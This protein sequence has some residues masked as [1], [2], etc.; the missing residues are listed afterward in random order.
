MAI[1]TPINLRQASIYSIFIRNFTPEGTFRAVIPELQRIKDL[2]TD[3]IWFLPIYPIGQD[4]RKGSAGSPYAIQDYRAVDPNYGT[5]DDFK[6]LVQ[7][8]H[9]LGMQVMLDIVYNHTSPDS[10]L[11]QEHPEWFYYNQQGERGNRV[12]EWTDIVD[13]DYR[14]PALWAYQIESL[15]QWAAIVDGFRCDVA[16]IVPLDF[17][18]QARAAV[19]EVNPNHI[20]LAESVHPDFILDLRRHGYDA[21]SDSEI[22]QAFDIAYD[23]EVYDYFVAYAKGV[24][25][26]EIYLDRLQMQEYIYPKNYLKLRNLENHDQVRAAELFPDPNLLKQW[27]AFNY[28]QKG[29]ALIYNGQEVMAAKTPS[30]FEADPIQWETGVNLS[31]FIQR[32]AAIKKGIAASSNYSLR[33]LDGAEAVEMTY[34]GQEKTYMG[35]F[36]LQPIHGE[37]AVNL[38]DGT[39]LNLLNEQNF[40][41]QNNHLQVADTPLFVEL[42]GEY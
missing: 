21:L 4:K 18:L 26:L 17:W 16:S 35:I 41:V 13:L 40:T 39:Y 19:A 1:N 38:Q 3:I 23:Y 2:G 34:H 10:V 30:L 20:W 42:F 6:A 22:F 29:P 11:V 15:K 9:A 33:K 14:Q 25:P 31:P 24:I 32:L 28:L 8:V 36:N 7:A 5:L 37:I 27:L 12:G